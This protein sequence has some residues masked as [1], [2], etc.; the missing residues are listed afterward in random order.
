MIMSLKQREIKF[1][2]EPYQ[3]HYITIIIYNKIFAVVQINKNL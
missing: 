3:L 1:K 2:I